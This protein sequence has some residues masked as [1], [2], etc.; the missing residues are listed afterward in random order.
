MDITSNG[1]AA[2][3]GPHAAQAKISATLPISSYARPGRGLA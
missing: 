3:I 1:L 2:V